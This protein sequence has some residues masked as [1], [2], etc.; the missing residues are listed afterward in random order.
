MK[1]IDRHLLASFVPPFGFG[2]AVTTFLLMINVL[3]SY[4]NLFLE[5]G[6]RFDVATEVLVLSLGHTIALTVPMATLIGVLMAMGHLA[7]DHEIT[8]MKACG[9]SLYRLA[10]PLLVIGMVLTTLMVAYNQYVLP[11]GNHRLRNR[12]FEIHQLRPTLQIKPNTFADISDRYTIFVRHKD[13]RTGRLEDVVLYQRQG[14]GD[15]SP[16]VVVAREGQLETLGPDRIRLDLYNGEMHRIPDS[17]D[18][19]SYNRTRFNRQTFIV[20]LDDD[21]DRL[22][23][24]T[25]RSER[26]MDLQMLRRSMTEQDSLAELKR[27]EALKSL[28]EVFDEAWRER[29]ASTAPPVTPGVSTLDEYRRWLMLTESRT[30]SL[31]LNHQVARSHRVKAGK[32]EVEWHKKFSIPF[33]CTVFVIVGMPLAVVS[34]RGGRG[35]SVGMSIGAFFLYYV[36]LST[37]EKLAD[38]GI[39]PPWVAMWL[40]NIVLGVAGAF[41]LRQSVQETRLI[42]FRLPAWLARILGRKA[43]GA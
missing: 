41:L 1:L 2:L 14:R 39:A 13:D 33:A 21:S 30:R 19:M 15:T 31:G 12:L 24:R 16:D 29:D 34:A 9:I 42:D 40:P 43:S 3:Q 37:G 22:R 25:A 26:E 6:I 35:V 7:S 32:Y 11:E 17:E 36:L 5:K 10:L 23:Q 38:R 20:T 28:R 4:I 8:A 18:P 27:T